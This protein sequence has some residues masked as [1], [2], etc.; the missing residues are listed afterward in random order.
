VES[1]TE[2]VE[3]TKLH[4]LAGDLSEKSGEKAFAA[5]VGRLG[6]ARRIES[7]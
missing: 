3:N 4:C 1:W 7:G 6:S 2:V 5:G